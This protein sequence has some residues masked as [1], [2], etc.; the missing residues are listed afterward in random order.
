MKRSGKKTF[1][2]TPLQ[3]IVI[4]VLVLG[5]LLFVSAIVWS[6]PSS[7]AAPGA[8]PTTAPPA[9][10]TPMPP[11]TPPPAEPP[12][13]VQPALQTTPLPV[14]PGPRAKG[15]G[16]QRLYDPNSVETLTGQVAAVQRG[17]M[18]KGGKGNLVRLTLKTDQGPVQIFLGPAK[19]VDAQT[20]KL[21]AGDQVEVKGSRITGPK[22][23]TT[24]TAAQVT[25][26]NEVL[27][28]RDDQG[29]PLW[30]RG[31]KK[32]ARPRKAL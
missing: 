30:P 32:R 1:G 3:R 16:R 20:L 4:P 15:A 17:P 11:A 31:Q 2:V 5:C 12:P 13:A 28:L 7:P 14:P 21:A 10:A 8:A 18:R 22:G 24:V 29:N 9:P 19:Y 27:K 23:K 25:K 26:G 6:Q